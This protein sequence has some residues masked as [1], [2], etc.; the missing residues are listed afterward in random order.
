MAGLIGNTFQVRQCTEEIGE[1]C[2]RLF[3]KEHSNR[4]WRHQRST[5]K[6]RD[7]TK[8]LHFREPRSGPRGADT[9]R[10]H[11]GERA[12]RAIPR[13]SVRD[14]VSNLVQT[15]IARRV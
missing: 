9:R 6:G 11:S 3:K 8:A 2:R 13:L 7:F 12:H 10:R 4:F 15:P 1:R 14:C 5:T